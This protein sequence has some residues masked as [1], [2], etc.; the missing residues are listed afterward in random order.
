MFVGANTPTLAQV[1]SQLM[2]SPFYHTPTVYEWSMSVQT[3]LGANWAVETAYIGNRGDH[4]DFLHLTGNQPM[5]G[6]TPLQAR[7]PWPDFNQLRFDTYD[8]YSNYNALTVKVTKRTSNGLSGLIGYTYS[9]AMDE[10]SGTSETEQPPQD[11]NNPN[12]EYGVA[13]TSLRNR[14]VVS[15]VYELP[16]GHGRKFINNANPAV[17]ALVGGWDLSSIFVVQSGYPFTVTSA[18]DF[19]NTNAGSARPDRTCGGQGPKSVNDWFNLN[20]F[21]TT[22]LQADLANGTPRFGNSRRNIL[23]GPGTVDLDASLIKRVVIADRVNT[24]FRAEVFNTLNHPNFAL[25][26]ATIGGASAGIISNT[27]PI[28][29]TGYNREI[30]LGLRV[31]F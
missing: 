27:V 31:T 18:S 5:P 19:S 7:R 26:N 29:A 25:P 2:P 14:L 24:E 4:L 23:V 22:A 9:K 8:A 11:D 17:N 10:N 16:V 12:A 15:G 21:T 30:Q 28:G 6:T 1:N 3:Q 20:C 13:D